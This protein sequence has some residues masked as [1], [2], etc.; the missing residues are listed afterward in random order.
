MVLTVSFGLSL[1]TGFLSPSPAQCVSIAANLTPAPGRQDHTTS[2]S[3]AVSTK[4]LGG[5]GTSPAEA[6]AKADQRRPSCAATRVHRIPP[7]TFVTIAIRPSIRGGTAGITKGVSS[8]PRSEIFLRKGLDTSRA[9]DVV[10]CPSGKSTYAR[11][12]W[13]RRRPIICSSRRSPL[14][15]AQRT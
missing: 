11:R 13:N 1:V 2:P 12:R 8:K 5:L 3:A 4:P 14:G 7:P 9:S 10:I 6:L 15:C